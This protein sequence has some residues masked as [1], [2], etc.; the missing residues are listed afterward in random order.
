VTLLWLGLWPALDRVYRRQARLTGVNPCDLVSA[1]TWNF[2]RQVHTLE[3]YSI[4]RVA[5]SLV[6]N[7]RRDVCR[8]WVRT[9]LREVC[10]EPLCEG[11]EAPVDP[12]LLFWSL[13]RVLGEDL[14]LLLAVVLE[15]ETPYELGVR[16]GISCEAARKRIRRA[17]IRA[18]RFL[19]EDLSHF[20]LLDGV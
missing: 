16:L 8:E 6:R 17:L 14:N 2:T 9:R 7:T 18:R 11:V 5:A 1:I 12:P 13:S 20:G 15:G 4:R 19:S 3:H 10:T